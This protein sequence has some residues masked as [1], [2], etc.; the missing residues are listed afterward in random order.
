MVQAFAW[1]G[2]VL[3]WILRILAWRSDQPFLIRWLEAFALFAAAF[4]L[5]YALG[6]SEGAIPF[7]TFYPAILTAALLLGWQEAAFVLVLSMAAGLY[8]FL[9]A[10][11]IFLPVGWALVGTFNIAIIIALKVLAL[12]L[13]EA[14]ERQRILFRELQ[15]RVAKALQSTIARLHI[16]RQTLETDPDQI[17]NLLD[18]A[19][20]QM[21]AT[22]DVHRR[23][24]DP[25]L[26]SRGP[27]PMLRAV[28]GSVVDGSS[29]EQTFHVEE[30]SLSLDQLSIIAMLVIEITN[31]AMKHV[32]QKHLGSR[33]QVTLVALPG[34]RA[35]L[36]IK[37]DG[38]GALDSSKPV[39][40]AQSLGMRII[41]DLAE[42]I[43][44]R[45]TIT[46]DLGTE[47]V[48]TFPTYARFAEQQ[49]SSPMP[50]QVIP[51][52][53]HKVRELR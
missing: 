48:V 8:F 6:W 38:P 25:I 45:V 22:A 49:Q 28:V 9:P 14:N 26:F 44:G 24:N 19:I 29:V 17:A 53:R 13:A 43:E 32:F 42:Q 30:L 33:L 4:A 11:M 5:R 21:T 36:G 50:H 41:E 12:D 20:Q 51:A 46:H 23:L 18:N 7:L 31:N 35:M 39:P 10:T 27:E 37:D 52:S 47:V 3:S 34:K 1:E 40:Q 2:G 16:L 15:H